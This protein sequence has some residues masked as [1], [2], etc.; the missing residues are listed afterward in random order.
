[1]HVLHAIH[2]RISKHHDECAASAALTRLCQTIDFA[3]VVTVRRV[4]SVTSV[5][6][7]TSVTTRTAECLDDVNLR[8]AKPSWQLASERPSMRDCQPA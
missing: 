5:A 3:A 1:V 6:S 8:L 4:T 7:V 2:V